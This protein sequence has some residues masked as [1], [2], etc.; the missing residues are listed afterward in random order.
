MAKQLGVLLTALVLSVFGAPANSA[1][2]S[3]KADITRCITR[4][5][6]RDTRFQAFLDLVE[7]AGFRKPGN[8]VALE[9]LETII[10]LRPEK[11]VPQ[12]QELA[13]GTDK[14]VAEEASAQLQGIAQRRRTK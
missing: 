14:H 8:I 2:L 9:R 13:R 5:Q 3:S 10:A 11:F 7:F 6:Q 4:L 1:T 12:L